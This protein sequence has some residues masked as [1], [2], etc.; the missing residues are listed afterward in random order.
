MPL[1]CVRYLNTYITELYIHIFLQSFDKRKK[2]K[3]KKRKIV[4]NY[5]CCI[6]VCNNHKYC[7]QIP[8][9]VNRIFQFFIFFFFT[10]KA[11]V[12][13]CIPLFQDSRIRHFQNNLESFVKIAG[14]MKCIWFK[15]LAAKHNIIISYISSL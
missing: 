15:F 13:Q 14:C 10:S 2:K 4:K 7:Y 6:L 1:D 5:F 11:K 8:S 9:R 12:Y 3:I